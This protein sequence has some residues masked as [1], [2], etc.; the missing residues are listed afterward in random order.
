MED[1]KKRAVAAIRSLPEFDGWS[2]QDIENNIVNVVRQGDPDRVGGMLSAFSRLDAFSGWKPDEILSNVADVFGA[3]PQQQLP[4]SPSERIAQLDPRSKFIEA[5][6]QMQGG[7]QIA[8]TLNALTGVATAPFNAFGVAAEGYRQIPIVGKA[9]AAPFDAMSAIPNAAGGVVRGAGQMLD[10]LVPSNAT[11]SD[12]TGIPQPPI[13]ET[14]R[15]LGGLTEAAAS[16]VLP[17]AGLRSVAKIRPAAARSQIKHQTKAGAVVGAGESI[18][19]MRRAGAFAAEFNVPLGKTQVRGGEVVAS[20]AEAARGIVGE[21]SKALDEKIIRP[22]TEAGKS[23]DGNAVLRAYE[24][25]RLEYL[26]AVTPKRSAVATLDRMI[27]ATKERLSRTQTPG[28][29]T[30]LE[31]QELKV[32]NNRYLEDFYRSVERKGGSLS[33]IEKVEKQVLARGTRSL[34]EQLEE[35]DP[36]VRKINWTSGAGLE[37]SNAI[38]EFAKARLRRDPSLTRGSGITAAA[39]GR[40]SGVGLFAVTE[41]MLFR[42]FRYAYHKAMSRAMGRIAGTQSEFARPDKVRTYS[43]PTQPT[44]G[45]PQFGSPLGVGGGGTDIYSFVLPYLAMQA[46]RR[47]VP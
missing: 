36:Q 30:P 28:R 47:E 34:R 21:L 8:G 46:A 12:A 15:A 2:P 4:Q 33:P 23:I 3:N 11:L 17:T 35:I 9:L 10:A 19:D 31:A 38:D 45:Q 40:P 22:A 39:A 18:P 1:R 14:S 24:D 16:Y 5:A 32:L 27:G 13:D 44:Q 42:P 6:K 7:N 29:L 20:G 25:M 41:L 37:L 43:Q 26:N